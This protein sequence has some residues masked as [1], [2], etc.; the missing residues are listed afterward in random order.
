MEAIRDKTGGAT[1]CWSM[2]SLGI[3]GAIAHDVGT[4]AGTVARITTGDKDEVVAKSRR[5]SNTSAGRE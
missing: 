5:K 3:E 2:R 4:I 1:M